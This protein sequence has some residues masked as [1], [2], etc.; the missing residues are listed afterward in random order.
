MPRIYVEWF[1]GRSKE[2]RDNLAKKVTEDVVAIVGVKPEAV[3]I[4]FKENPKEKV[5]KAGIA[6]SEQ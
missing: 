3:N 1:E 2:I 4:V 6:A 5:Y